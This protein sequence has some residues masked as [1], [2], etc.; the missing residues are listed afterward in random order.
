[1]E[2]YPCVKYANLPEEYKSLFHQESNRGHKLRY[3]PRQRAPPCTLAE[4]KVKEFVEYN[5]IDLILY[6]EEQ[7]R[8]SEEIYSN[9]GEA[10]VV[11][12]LNIRQKPSDYKTISRKKIMKN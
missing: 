6:N 9:I 1:M 5:N 8:D 11:R 7:G 10:I 12:F 4:E 3:N 2:L